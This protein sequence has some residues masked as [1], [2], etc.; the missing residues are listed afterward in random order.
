MVLT[1]APAALATWTASTM[2][3]ELGVARR[4]KPPP[5]KSVLISTCS[6]LSPAA[7]AAFAWSTVW[8]WVPVQI[9]HRS[10]ASETRQLSGSI[11]AC[12]R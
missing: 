1:G 5:R 11:G 2:K 12:A 6:G 7:R 10:G 8:N 3:S 4:P 9:W